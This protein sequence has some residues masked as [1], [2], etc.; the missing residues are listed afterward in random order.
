[1]NAP[2]IPSPHRRLSTF[3]A[4]FAAGFAALAVRLVMVH[5]IRPHIPDAGEDSIDRIARPAR[6][7]AILSAD[8]KLL[9]WS[10]SRVNIQAD[11]VV[12]GTN[13]SRLR[14]VADAIV[15]ML[16]TPTNGLSSDQLMA[17]LTPRVESRRWL[18]ITT[19]R[20]EPILDSRQRPRIDTTGQPLMRP[21][22]STNWNVNPNFTNRA[23]VLFTNV[24][25]ADWHR[26]Q[27]N[28]LSLKFPEQGQLGTLQTN[29]RISRP[30]S[31]R[32]L[33]AT[34]GHEAASVRRWQESSR[35]V[36]KAGKQL[37]TELNEIRHNAL[38]AQPIELRH[39]PLDSVAAHV[40]GYT[41]NDDRHPRLGLPNPLRGATG[42]EH[43]LDEELTGS[44]GLLV[45]H[46][47]KG[48]ELVRLR[49]RDVAARDGLS[50]QL[51]I[52]TR[53]Q[54][55][56]EEALDQ[57]YAALNPKA[58]I[59]IVIRPATGEILALGNR[60]NYNPNQ[61]HEGDVEARWN[62]AITAPTE[63]GSTF[64]LCTYAVALDLGKLTLSQPI[65]CEGGTWTPG[66][67]KAINDV[68][69]HGLNVI[70]AEEAFAKS[71][72]VAAA[73]IGLSLTT[74]EFVH[75]MDQLG[76]LHRT[77]I[78]YRRRR[79]ASGGEVDDW[80]GENA[81]GI[82]SLIREGRIG[83]E[84]QG[85]LSFGYGLYVTPLQ[86]A[87]AA[88]ALANEGKLM[89]P[90]LVRELRTP[91]G[92]L[93]KR[94]EPTVSRQ[95][96]SPATAHAMMQAMRRVITSGTGKIAALADYEVAG[97]T[98]TAHKQFNGQQSNEKYLSTFVGV[99]PADKPE[100]CI[101]V[102]ADETTKRTPGSHFGGKA[103]GP[104]FTNIAARAAAILALRPTEPP[105]D[106][107]PVKSAV[108]ASEANQTRAEGDPAASR[109]PLMERFW[110]DRPR[111]NSAVLR[112]ST[113]TPRP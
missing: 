47:A 26:L 76:F 91:E 74:N 103:C 1:M 37:R 95:A 19:N 49:E 90:L 25:P 66:V 98:G 6:R 15:K 53:I 34:F 96:V 8:E 69:G 44:P 89:K 27:T 12:I 86:T 18:T 20:F 62:R 39:Y 45:T 46:A 10:E 97:K 40:L 36:T 110:A 113:L 35:A 92:I 77:G 102:L 52:D 81:G 106:P 51:T 58:L 112:A 55:V 61:L 73:K 82:P 43:M 71:S 23:I 107:D 48:R 87:F 31:F 33:A 94:F 2:R 99:L 68:E 11:P 3:V 14:T 105:A 59:V 88:A 17:Q 54:T 108:R 75:G 63:P 9:A 104:I 79:G 42:I 30:S 29:L 109:Q 50:A 93:V 56:V 83:T 111:D 65:N 28:L 67:G 7:G 100:L 22:L 32:R 80:G 16:G 38:V 85:R 64:K 4:L 13:L 21:V 84:L 70:S 78:F 101:L 60:P 41:T 57:G 24:Q 72:N 5:V